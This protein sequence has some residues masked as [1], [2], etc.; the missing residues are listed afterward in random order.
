MLEFNL[1][2]RD[3]QDLVTTFKYFANARDQGLFAMRQVNHSVF[4]VTDIAHLSDELERQRWRARRC[5]ESR[6]WWRR[7]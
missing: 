3:V 4:A 7:R 6:F 2:R 5:H 1:E